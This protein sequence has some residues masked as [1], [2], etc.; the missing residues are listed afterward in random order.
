[1]WTILTESFW[2]N[3]WNNPAPGTYMGEKAVKNQIAGSGTTETITITSG[4]SNGSTLILSVIAR[5]TSI[6]GCSVA[7]SRGNTWTIDSISNGSNNFLAVASTRQN[8]ATLQNGDTVTFT[9]GTAPGLGRGMV[10]EEFY[11]LVSASYIDAIQTNTFGSPTTAETTASLVMSHAPDI[12]YAAYTLANTGLS[13]I[14]VTGDITYS[15]FTTSSLPVLATDFPKQLFHQYKNTTTAGTEQNSITSTTANSFQAAFIG[16]KVLG[17]PS[18]TSQ[19]VRITGDPAPISFVQENAHNLTTGGTG[20]TQSIPITA[21]S[22][23]GNT[24]ILS[25]AAAVGSTTASVADSKGN[26]WTVDAGPFV[27]GTDFLFIASTRQ[28]AGALTTSDTVTVT[29]G[30]AAAPA[31]L[32]RIEEFVGLVTSGTYVDQVANN[33]SATRVTSGTSGTT[34]ATSQG[35]ELAYAAFCAA[36]FST[37]GGGAGSGYT[38]TPSGYAAANVADYKAIG[39]EYKILTTTG[40][41]SAGYNFNTTGPSGGPD[42]YVGA[43]VTYFGALAPTTSSISQAVRV[44]GSGPSIGFVS[45]PVSGGVSSASSST[46]FTIASDLSSGNTAILSYAAASALTTASVTDSRGNTWTID[47]GPFVQGTNFLFVA[48]TRMDVGTLLAGDTVTVTLGATPSGAARLYRIEEFYGLATSSYVDQVV[49]NGVGTTSTTGTVGPT[50]TTSQND[51]LVFVAFNSANFITGG[52][53]GTGYTSTPTFSN[54]I[55]VADYHSLSTEYKIISSTGTQTAGVNFD[56]TGPSGGPTSYEGIIVTYKGATTS[57][58]ISQDIRVTAEAISNTFFNT[59]LTGQ[60]TSLISQV[61]RLT[62][63]VSSNISYGARLTGQN[64]SLISQTTRLMGEAASNTTQATR[65]TGEFVSL[66]SQGVR[67]TGQTTSLQSQD[68]RIIGQSASLTSQNIRVIG[69]ASSNTNYTTHIFGHLLSDSGGFATRLT[70]ETP[71][72]TLQNTRLIGETTS[73]ISQSIRLTGETTSSVTQAARIT[74][75]A[76]TNSSYSTRITGLAGVVVSQDIRVTGETSSSTSYAARIFGH[77]VADSGSQS[78]RVTGEAS[79]STSFGAKLSGQAQSLLSQVTKI[80]GETTSNISQISRVVGEAQSLISYAIRITGQNSTL[81]SYSTRVIGEVSS[82]ISYITR[83]QGEAVSAITYTVR[84]TGEN[85]SNTS[86]AARIFGYLLSNNSIDVRLVGD[87]NANLYNQDVRITG[88]SISLVSQ[89]TCIVGQI[90]SNISQDTRIQGQIGTNVLYN[91][92][93]VGQATNSISL[94]TRITGQAIT[95]LSTAVRVV[96]QA[97]SS[98]SQN[99]RIIGQAVSSVLFVTRIIGENSSSYS[100]SLQTV[101]EDTTQATWFAHLIGE[102]TTANIYSVGLIGETSSITTTDIRIAGAGF[103]V[104]TSWGI[105]ITGAPNPVGKRRRVYSESSIVKGTEWTGLNNPPA[106]SDISQ[107]GSGTHV[108]QNDGESHL[109]FH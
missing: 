67:L 88:Q 93:V 53:P 33:Q 87:P 65:V 52:S 104:Q 100:Q 37:S 42:S 16:Y 26:T 107:S 69:E 19:A 35:N 34:S 81:A 98:L 38:D 50:S 54:A 13:S 90:T 72:S 64:T 80:V 73:L 31:R 60:S 99:A 56:T 91:T 77:L 47:A 46:T 29:L 61:T 68:V 5:D 83:V 39:V 79:S 48:S 3:G 71:S 75:E 95:L 70:G 27:Q 97:V 36:N 62:G 82:S 9:W 20:V 7:D 18:S 96:G 11:G 17:T 92:R 78:T 25:F 106:Q 89:A 40:T 15:N 85:S 30:T 86:V 51:E 49:N 6:V 57:T 63:E 43:I 103:N 102:D 1:M 8:V 41:Q 22:T 23:L 2:D 66:T 94:T 108:R 24:L 14:S 55:N 76:Q 59:R 101:G 84:I 58:S 4:A 32:W 12:L 105:R 28:D 74:G 45:E 10:I 21:G 44:T 109:R